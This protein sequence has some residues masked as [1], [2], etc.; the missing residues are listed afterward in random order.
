MIRRVEE[1]GASVDANE[2]SADDPTEGRRDPAAAGSSDGAEDPT[3]VE[4]A[5][6]ETGA[7]EAADRWPAGLAPTDPNSPPDASSAATSAG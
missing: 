1:E 6:P 4:A 3:D 2:S 7:I 5:G